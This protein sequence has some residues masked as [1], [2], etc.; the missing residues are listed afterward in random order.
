MTP[1]IVSDVYRLERREADRHRQ[2]PD[3]DADLRQGGRLLRLPVCRRRSRP[4]AT[5]SRRAWSAPTPTCSPGRA[6]TGSRCSTSWRSTRPEGAIT[7]ATPDAPLCCFQDI[8]RGKWQTKLDFT[9]GHLYAYVMNNYWFTNYL[10]GQGGELQRSASR[11]PAGPRPTGWPRPGSAGRP[12]IRSCA[13]SGEG[14][15]QR[16]ADRAER[17]PA[18]HRRAER[19]LGRAPAGRRRAMGSSCGSGS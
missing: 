17:Q 14:Q 18:L 10:A 19:V 9:N 1:K 11:S 3:E 12:R 8:N 16:A 6:S 15:P 5:R 2:Q 7:W 13:T 4:S